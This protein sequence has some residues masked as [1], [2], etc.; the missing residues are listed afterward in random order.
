M[1]SNDQ[2]KDI[3]ICGH[4]ALD[5]IIIRKTNTE[6]H[7]L[8]G[9]VTYGSLAAASYDP[10]ALAGVVSR[11][12]EDFD[13]SLFSLFEGYNI[14]LSGVKQEGNATTGY[15]LDYHDEGRDLKLLSRAPN[16]EI[17][18]FPELFINAKAIH[19]TPIANEFSSQF[20]E[21]LANHEFTQD[22]LIGIDV[23]GIIRDFDEENN[24]IMRSDPEIQKQ[25]FEMLQ[26]FGSVCFSKPAIMKRELLQE[27]MIWWKQPNI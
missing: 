5:T 8:G 15:L 18:D 7:S 16:I 11:I 6:F 17:E 25:V 23:Q 12:G 26:Q 21:D 4:F 3:V 1:I 22:T 2:R 13:T 27:L 9:G 14:D 19:M 10:E 20:I 24:V